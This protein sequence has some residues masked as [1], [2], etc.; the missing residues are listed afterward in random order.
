MD[1]NDNGV[2]FGILKRDPVMISYSSSR[3]PEATLR[4]Q[5][6]C[7]KKGGI[8]PSLHYRSPNQSKA[9]KEVFQAHCPVLSDP[10][11]RQIYQNLFSRFA[12]ESMQKSHLI[13]LGCGTGIKEQWLAR[14]MKRMGAPID[15]FTA[16]DVSERL[17]Q[18]SMKRVL[19]Y[20]VES[21]QA[22][23]ID[24]EAADELRKALDQG[25]RTERRIYTFFGL[26]PNLAP[27]TVLRILKTLLRPQDQ[28]L[29]S[30]NLAPVRKETEAEEE[31]AVKR[32]LPQYRNRE[33]KQ[34]LSML[35]QEQG[36]SRKMISS[37]KFE[38]GKER[39]LRSVVVRAAVLADFEW[40]LG[41]KKISMKKGNRLTVFQSR[42]WT[43][44]RFERW[45]KR[46]GFT[47]R[48]VEMTSNREEGVWWVER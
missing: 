18:I 23:V 27:V 37:L 7:L 28:L 13:G 40:E 20:L 32:I 41:S 10:S 45:L 39:E 30:A 11:F 22:W 31:R 35:F 3:S 38:I 36:I 26:V 1:R 8:D 47:V 4:K 25:D 9:W 33:T 14:S 34:W 21:P 19:P 46:N 5:I 17:C 29:I 44:L 2:R 12:Q 42:R 43:P 15:R 24:L 6:S 48:G 16:V